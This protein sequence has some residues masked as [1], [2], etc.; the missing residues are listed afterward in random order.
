MSIASPS[1]SGNWSG[2]C[3]S[4]RVVSDYLINS[5]KASARGGEVNVA[6]SL[7]GDMIA[8]NLRGETLMVQSGSFVAC[9]KNVAI[10]TAWGGAKT[11][12]ASEGLI[13]LKAS[14]SGLFVLSSYG[15]I[16]EMNLGAGEKYTVDTGHLV[17]FPANI[18]F[19]VMPSFPGSSPNCPPPPKAAK[20]CRSS[21]ASFRNPVS[22]RN[23]VSLAP[24]GSFSLSRL[25][26]VTCQHEEL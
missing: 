21:W 20:G 26:I 23:R 4:I 16:H 9:E 8:L 10:D 19:Q 14:G 6:P 2:I 22:W 17:A 24:L 1:A 18:G 12:F 3:R 7:P 13:M 15:A 11:F 5:Y 25:P